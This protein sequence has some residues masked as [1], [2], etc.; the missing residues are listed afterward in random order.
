MAGYD[1][2]V[3]EVTASRGPVRAQTDLDL[4]PQPIRINA[5]IVAAF[6]IE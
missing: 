4:D 3:I 5:K 6:E 2:D 1:Q